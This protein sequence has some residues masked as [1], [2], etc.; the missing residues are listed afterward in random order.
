MASNTLP[1]VEMLTTVDRTVPL[2]N[3]DCGPHIDIQENVVQSI[4]PENVKI[5]T[6]K[7][8]RVRDTRGASEKHNFKNS[9]TGLIPESLP[10]TSTLTSE[11]LR[12]H[13]EMLRKRKSRSNPRVYER[14]R[15]R[16]LLSSQR[17]DATRGVRKEVNIRRV[18]NSRDVHASR[19]DMCRAKVAFF[20]TAVN[21]APQPPVISR[22][23][24][25][26]Q[27]V[28]TQSVEYQEIHNFS[29][30]L[31]NLPDGKRAEGPHFEVKRPAD[32]TCVI[33]KCAEQ[34]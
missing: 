20:Q 33:L 13:Q 15:G 23:D 2:T 9:M 32:G 4:V 7:H 19:R 29:H 24:V 6:V 26:H 30:E 31:V 27:Y 17:S 34:N 14:E 18:Q 11:D 12:R 21:I 10:T 3:A 16:A 25:R 1:N 8:V 28:L 22:S 5:F